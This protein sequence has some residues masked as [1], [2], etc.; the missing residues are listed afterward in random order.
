MEAPPA[1]TG[2]VL[3]WLGGRVCG[4][5]LGNHLDSTHTRATA[6]Q[7]RHHGL[8]SKLIRILALT[9]CSGPSHFVDR[10]RGG[11][12]PAVANFSSL[13]AEPMY[14]MPAST[15]ALLVDVPNPDPQNIDTTDVIRALRL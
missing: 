15:D 10:K 7:H 6:H 4:A 11:G 14:K 8:S 2:A 9:S 1:V 3:L 13:E 5:L 12:A